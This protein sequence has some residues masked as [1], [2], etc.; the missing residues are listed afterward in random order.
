MSVLIANGAFA[1][2]EPDLDDGISVWARASGDLSSYDPRIRELLCPLLVPGAVVV[3]GGAFIGDHTVPFADVVGPSGRVWAF[4]VYPLALDCLAYN[5]QDL[6]QVTVVAAALAERRGSVQ[7]R[8]ASPCASMSYVTDAECGIPAVPLDAFTF[9]RLD[10]IKLDL[11]GSELR[12]LRGAAQQ[13]DRHHPV[14]IT[15][16]GCQL[17]RYGDCHA[18]LVAFMAAHGYVGRELPRLHPPN[19]DVFDMLFQVAA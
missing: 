8:L 17:R 16:T 4:E 9:D 13:L 6:P 19:I 12:A 14:V 2:L 15:E 7:L 1:V 10:V 11:E 3:D 18:D 5:T